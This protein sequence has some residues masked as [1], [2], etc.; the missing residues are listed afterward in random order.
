MK[1]LTLQRWAAEKYE[2]PPP[3]GTLRRWAR[4]GNIYPPP[5]LHGTRYRVREDAVYIRPNKYAKS[6]DAHQSRKFTSKSLVGR[7]INGEAS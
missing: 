1:M 3:I 6:L 2:E 7:L 5:E 4:N